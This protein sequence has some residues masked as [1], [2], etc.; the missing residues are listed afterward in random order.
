MKG[1]NTSHG[2]KN[3]VTVPVI[4]VRIQGSNR[5]KLMRYSN[6]FVELYTVTS[7]K[8]QGLVGSSEKLQRFF[9]PDTNHR[10]E[11]RF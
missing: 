9:I 6:E 5:F 10:H 8:N 3:D 4:R 2:S 11:T 7:N 1:C